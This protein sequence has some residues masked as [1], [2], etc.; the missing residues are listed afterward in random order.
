M[1]EKCL[2]KRVSFS[3]SIRGTTWPSGGP[4]CDSPKVPS[5]VALNFTVII[6]STSIVLSGEGYRLSGIVMGHVTCRI[7]LFRLSKTYATLYYL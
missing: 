6:V 2:E 5:A 4:G 3:I 1:K 7:F